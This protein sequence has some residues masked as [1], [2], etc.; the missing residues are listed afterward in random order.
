MLMKIQYMIS[1]SKYSS[2]PEGGLRERD[3][4][5]AHVGAADHV[6]VEVVQHEEGHQRAPDRDVVEYRPVRRIECDLK[7][8]Y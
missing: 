2:E 5:R 6:V 1:H 7:Q 8:R 3:G 4:E